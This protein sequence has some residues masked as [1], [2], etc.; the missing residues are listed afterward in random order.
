MKKD[1]LHE[2]TRDEASRRRYREK[3]GQFVESQ[4]TK[5]LG[6]A[7]DVAAGRTAEEDRLLRDEDDAKIELPR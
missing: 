5:E 7:K 4:K 1:E 2:E 3:T 6:R